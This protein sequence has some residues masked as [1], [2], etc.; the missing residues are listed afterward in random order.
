M[1]VLLILSALG[2]CISLY[3]YIIESKIKRDPT[4]KPMCDIS[5]V[6]SCSKP[7]TSPYAN[8]FYVSNAFLGMLYYVSVAL[9]AIFHVYSLLLI[10]ALMA[11]IISAILAYFLYFKIKTLCLVCTALYIINILILIAVLMR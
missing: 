7:V 2:F 6:I 4:F 10:A 3:A 1:L 8:L 11:C 5:D 9:F